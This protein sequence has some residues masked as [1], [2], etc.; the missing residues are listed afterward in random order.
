MLW[1]ISIGANW[2]DLPTLLRSLSTKLITSLLWHSVSSSSCS[3]LSRPL[4]ASSERSASSRGKT[5]AMGCL[6][7]EEAT[8]HKFVTMLHDLYTDSRRSS[9]MYSPPCSLTRFFLRSMS[10]S[11]PS[12]FHCPT[13]PVHSQPSSVNVS[14][15][16]S[17]RLKYPCVTDGPR[18][19][20]SP[21]GG[22][23]VEK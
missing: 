20:T 23:L 10:D 3:Y 16:I 6:A 2:F 17:G 21:C 4:A 11:V 7:S 5:T 1:S 14:A 13:S 18:I 22:S 19:S 9:A 15:V 8:R 12:A